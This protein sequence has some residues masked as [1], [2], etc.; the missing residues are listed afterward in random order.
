MKNTRNKLLLCSYIILLIF[1]GWEIFGGDQTPWGGKSDTT[2]NNNNDDILT[3]G[4]SRGPQVLDPLIF[5]P[6]TRNFMVDIYEG[7]VK[8]D[9]NLTIKPG[10]AVTWG[11]LNK[12]TW[13]FTVRPGV[14]FHNG[15]YVTPEDIVYSITKAKEDKKSELK[16]MLGSIERIDIISHSKIHIITKYPDP[17][18]LEKLAVT[19]IYPK[20]STD[21]RKDL[22]TGPYQIASQGDT[23]LVEVK[24]NKYWGEK[25]AYEKV[26]RSI[27]PK[28][29]DRLM[30]L[31][32]GELS[33]L[34]NVPPNI[35]C[36][37]NNSYESLNCEKINN[38]DILI[39]STP[40][41]EVNFLAFNLNHELLRQHPVR[42][43][44]T[45]IFD[46]K[47]FIEM[48]YGFARPVTQFVSNGV[49]GYNPEIKT[50]PYSI[51]AAKNEIE[52]ALISGFEQ[53][54]ITFDYPENLPTIGQYVRDQFQEVD[55]QVHLNPL[56]PEKLLEKI[57]AG[58]SALYFFGWKSEL[59]DSS[60]FLNSNGHSQNIK[61]GYGAYNGT[62]LNNEKVDQLI[63]KASQEL[64]TKERMKYLQKAMEIIVTDE[65][66]GIPLYESEV[67]FAYNKKI[68]F[69][70][71]IDGFIH[72]SEIAPSQ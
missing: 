62:G 33:I 52:T 69:Q 21:F 1:L 65:I 39:V 44:L 2:K 72:A 38:N 61:K 18:L 12:T 11:L 34:A 43:A 15:A 70:P 4:F 60:D 20:G 26:I 24:F 23:E 17:L 10:L 5:N 71:R 64:E 58:E 25:P 51:E 48:S 49:F 53:A 59:G 46:K 68:N 47:V 14:K 36:S 7:L 45:K 54:E 63:E 31:E 3:I 19:Y 42:N 9:K 6:E 67:I 22:G 50:P 13:E 28:K 27:I 29:A 41:L 40:N 30:A 32:K 37:K 55:I 57:K 66:I 8:T 35:A 16:D 56:P